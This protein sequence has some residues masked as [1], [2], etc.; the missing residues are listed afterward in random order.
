MNSVVKH[1]KRLLGVVILL[2]GAVAL[3]YYVKPIVS[4]RSQVEGPGQVI[5]ASDSVRDEVVT[6]SDYVRYPGKNGQNAL[7][8]LEELAPVDKQQFDFGVMVESIGGVKPSENQF[9]KLYINGQ[10]SPV[11]ADMLQ[12]C[13]GD[14]VEWL[15]EDISNE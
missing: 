8:L 4:C 2:G 3:T 10:G 12:T 15:I 7:V 11:G 14:V 5:S 13:R 6:L 1:W 9:W